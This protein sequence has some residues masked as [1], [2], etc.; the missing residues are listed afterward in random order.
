M[1]SRRRRISD[2]H[3]VE[4]IGVLVT[5]PPFPMIKSE[6]RRA[7]AARPA[8]HPLEAAARIHLG[9]LGLIGEAPASPVLVVSPTVG[10]GNTFVAVNLAIAS[11]RVAP[12]L[13]VCAA[14]VLDG[15]AARA[16]SI[17]SGTRGI[18]D[19]SQQSGWTAAQVAELAAPT[20]VA[21]L[22]VLAAGTSGSRDV[23]MLERAL[24]HGLGDALRSAT[25]RVIV[26]APALEVSNAALQLAPSASSVGMVAAIGITDLEHLQRALETLRD[27]GAA[28]PHVILNTP[29]RAASR[30]A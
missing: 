12:T 2:E 24:S 13:L 17:P 23:E 18:A 6:W 21:N 1:R 26:D 22:S 27:A 19:A 11:A 4:E 20:R 5:R 8:D 9:P 10:S 25:C 29:P 16:L 15:G 3:D 14:D 7:A 28:T 30:R